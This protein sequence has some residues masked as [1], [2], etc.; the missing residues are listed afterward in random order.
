MI[1]WA[2]YALCGAGIALPTLPGLLQLRLPHNQSVTV[3]PHYSRDPRYLGRSFRAKAEP[4]LKSNVTGRVQFLDR[5]DEFALVKDGIVLEG[6]AP[7]RDVLLSRSTLRTGPLAVLADAYAQGPVDIGSESSLRAL[8]ADGDTTVG[9]GTTFHRWIDV[10]GNLTVGAHS[11]LGYSASAT[12][13]LTLGPGTRFHR[14]YALPVAV[15]AGANAQ[16]SQRSAVLRTSA[17]I[18]ESGRTHDGDAIAPHD[19]VVGDRAVVNGTIT[20]GGNVVVGAG[21]RIEGNIIARGDVT[22]EAD[23]FV[24]GHIFSD[25]TIAVGARATI[26]SAGAPKTVESLEAL[27]LAPGATI[28]GWVICEGG[29]TAAGI[30]S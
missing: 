17:L 1:E 4:V 10:D 23:T 5:R 30:G 28:F 27:Y 13:S 29:G 18:V 8:A 2:A 15:A 20:S 22:L 26:G 25:R 12:G 19:V 24:G 16:P 11:D 3:D 9:V 21:S 6:N 14:L 7:V